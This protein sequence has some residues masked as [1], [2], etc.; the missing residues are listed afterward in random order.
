MLGKSFKIV[1][2]RRFDLYIDD[3]VCAPDEAIVKIEYA[4]ICKAD[5]RYYIGAR[6]K[7]TLGFKYPMNLL[8]E[9]VGSI[10]L[11]KTNRFKVGERVVLVPNIIPKTKHDCVH[12]VC[13]RADLGE[14]YCPNSF[15]ASSNYNGFAREYVN[16]PVDYLIKIPL[17]LEPQLATFTE[18]ISVAISASRRLNLNGDEAIGVWG[19]GVLGYILSTTLRYL[20]KGKIVVVGKNEDK[21]RQ[22]KAH[23]HYLAGD[24]KLFEE[25]IQVAYECVGGGFSAEAINEIIDQIVVGGRIILT[26]VA[27]EQVGINTRKILEKGLSLYGVT[28]SNRNDFKKALTLLENKEFQADISPLILNELT[29]SDITDFYR[30]FEAELGNKR[31]GKKI[32]RFNL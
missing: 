29:I 22:F 27:E 8:H 23:A 15:F 26:G 10:I 14:N 1:E 7:R 6:D 4:A 18:L 2:P 3:L 9:A 24:P 11:D 25:E 12:C 31:L 5:L 20:H 16:Y 13:A 28:R 17:D 30:A 21:L 32:L 19:D